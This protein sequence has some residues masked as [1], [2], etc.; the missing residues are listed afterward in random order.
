MDTEI[1]TYDIEM[2]NILDCIADLSS[3]EVLTPPANAA[4]VCD[5]LPDSVWNKDAKFLDP[6]SKSGVFLQEIAKRLVEAQMRD[7][8]YDEYLRRAAEVEK[9]KANRITLSQDD[10]IFEDN[11][12]SVVDHVMHDQIFGIAPTELTGIMSRKT[13]YCSKNA[14]GRYSVSHF[15]NHDGNIAYIPA[16]HEWNA[17]GSCKWCGASQK[18]FERTDGTEQYAYRFIH[19]D[20]PRDVI[21]ELTGDRDM[22]FDVIIGNPPYQMSDGGG[23]GG[24][25]AMP[26]YNKFVEQAKK[27]NPRYLTMIIPA[28]WYSGGKGLDSFREEM[29]GDRRIRKLVDYTDS[30]DCFSSVS[31]KGGICYF[32]WERDA[33]GTCEV[34]NILNGE[35]DTSTRELVSDDS[36]FFIRYNR[37]VPIVKKTYSPDDSHFDEIV[38]T[39]KPFGLASTFKNFCSDSG[40]DTCVIYANKRTDGT[41]RVKRSEI[42]INSDWIDQHKIFITFAYGAGDGFPHQIINKPI[43]GD[44]GTCCTE[45]YLVVGPFKDAET[46]SNC[47]SYMKTKF[48]RFLVLQ[49]KLTQNATSKVYSLVPMQDFSESWTDE[50]LYAKYGITKKEQEFIDAMIRPMA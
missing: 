16:E 41:A 10:A 27:L 12:Q 39:R 50:K 43:I 8:G 24:S 20:D 48:F 2:P 47:L 32:L 45:T 11:L 15:D 4:N 14:S 22:Q 44:V 19:V 31:I 29:F 49:C 5:M 26:L 42:A 1:K 38:S 18:E 25:S 21:E 46:T 23:G 28:R 34:S 13:V 3:D 40:D 35:T 36:G 9:K 7:L 33:P 37:A 6:C 30:H 17:N